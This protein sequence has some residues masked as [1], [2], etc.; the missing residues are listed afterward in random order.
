VPDDVSILEA[1][2]GMLQKWNS[3]K[4]KKKPSAGLESKLKQPK[5][6]LTGEDVFQ[7]AMRL[8]PEEK[9]ELRHSPR[10]RSGF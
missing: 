5:V 4:K 3:R 7:N 2:G 8:F 10:V 9:E 1:I 6:K